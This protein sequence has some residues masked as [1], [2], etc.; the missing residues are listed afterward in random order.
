MGFLYIYIYIH[1]SASQPASQAYRDQA[2]HKETHCCKKSIGLL[3]VPLCSRECLLFAN[4]RVRRGERESEAG[5]KEIGIGGC[6]STTPLFPFFRF[7][8]VEA[9]FS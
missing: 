8:W 2:S 9:R 1:M 3:Q 4:E 6:E 7:V 5:N